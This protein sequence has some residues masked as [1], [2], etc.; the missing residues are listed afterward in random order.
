MGDAAAGTGVRHV[1]KRLH[2]RLHNEDPTAEVF[3]LELHKRRFICIQLPMYER[4]WVVKSVVEVEGVGRGTKVSGYE[5]FEFAKAGFLSRR[6]YSS[7]D[8]CPW[9]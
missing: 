5:E 7:I 1:E 4:H 2:V 9:K 8:I 6:L 3:G